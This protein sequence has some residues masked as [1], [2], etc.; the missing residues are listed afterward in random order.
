MYKPK[1]KLYNKNWSN[2][3]IPLEYMNIINNFTYKKNR[4]V[5]FI[6]TAN[7]WHGVEP[8]RQPEGM[9]RRALA[10]NIGL[11][12]SKYLDLSN[13]IIESFYRRIE[14]PKFNHINVHKNIKF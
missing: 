14:S 1:N 11:P 2:N 10:I 8:I 6:K 12:E 7:S 5:G 4:L 3:Y 13:R 9:W